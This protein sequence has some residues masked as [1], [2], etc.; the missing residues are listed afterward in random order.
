MDSAA[1]PASCHAGSSAAPAVNKKCPA[2]RRDILYFVF[3]G[4]EGIR[5]P[6]PLHA[7]QVRYQLRHSPKNQ[8]FSGTSSTGFPPQILRFPE[9]FGGA[10]GIRT[11]DPL[12]AM[13]VRYQLRHSPNNL[14]PLC[15]NR[16][17]LYPPGRSNSSTLVQK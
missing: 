13:Q 8:C 3:G 14:F 4:A 12:H 7:M 1:I 15:L 5:T 9:E 17:N 16:G 6:D 11:P 10:E 2:V